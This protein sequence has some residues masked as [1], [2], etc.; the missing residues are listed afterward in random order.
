M[1]YTWQ[2]TYVG[3]H[4]LSADGAEWDEVYNVYGY[5]WT[6]SANPLIDLPVDNALV[7]P[8]AAHPTIPNSYVIDFQP[9]RLG[10]SKMCQA[11]VSYRSSTTAVD[12]SPLSR[13]AEI[14][15]ESE[16]VEVPTFRRLDGSLILNTAGDLVHGLTR[17]VNRRIFN[18]SKNV[19]AFP[20]WLLSYSD[21]AVNSDSVTIE[22]IAYA[23]GYLMLQ[24]VRATPYTS[25][26]VNG[27]T[28]AY[29]VMT[30][31]LVYDPRGWDEKVYNRGL[32]AYGEPPASSSSSTTS[33]SSSR[34]RWIMDEDEDGNRTPVDEPQFLDA[35]GK[36]LP[37]PI[38]EGDVIELDGVGISSLPFNAVLPLT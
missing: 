7:R 15:L 26:Q 13:P 17:K 22:G 36:R 23:A 34:P 27:V 31:A 5:D 21:N 4:S 3:N 28:V 6:A 25:E 24:K 19:A 10:T 14:T 38:V 8:N 29:R 1:P 12:V 33:G 20:S 18:Y 37:H 2:R 16:T 11:T 30:F 35:D 9:Q 32:R